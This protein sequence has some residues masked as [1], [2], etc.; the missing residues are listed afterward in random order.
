VYSYVSIEE[1]EDV[2][3]GF[4]RAPIAGERWTVGRT[5]QSDHPYSVLAG[6]IAGP[7]GRSIV[8]DDDFVRATGGCLQCFKAKVELVPTVVDW[9]DDGQFHSRVLSDLELL[10]LEDTPQLARAAS[11]SL[12]LGHE[13]LYNIFE[14]LIVITQQRM[15]MRPVEQLCEALRERGLKVTPQ[16]R[17]IFEALQES[18]EHPSAEDIYRAV[19]E[20]MPDV[21][22]ATVYHTLNDLV[23]MGELVELDLGEGKMRYDPCTNGHCHLVCLGCRSVVDVMRQ[24]DFHRLLPEGALGYQVERCEVVFYGHCPECQQELS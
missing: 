11:A 12:T 8:D 7:V 14:L 9:D 16:R 15:A 23:A 19:T 24:P 10:L 6:Q 18:T 21:S 20:V 5:I 22:V 1:E 13:A 3:P 2:P 17:L 4:L